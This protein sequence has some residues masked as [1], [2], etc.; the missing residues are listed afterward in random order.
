MVNIRGARAPGVTITNRYLIFVIFF[1]CFC[2]QEEGRHQQVNTITEMRKQSSEL[3]D[4]LAQV[5]K[6]LES[7]LVMTET[8]TLPTQ[9][10][11][12]RVGRGGK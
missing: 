9:I 1:C 6:E 4:E 7:N 11:L 10:E 5:T 3:K 8:V 2:L 12:K